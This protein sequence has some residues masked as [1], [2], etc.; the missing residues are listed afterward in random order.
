MLIDF[1]VASPTKKT[2]K[3]IAES[4]T[5]L[6]YRTSFEPNE[7]NSDWTTICAT[8]MMLSHPAVLAIQQELDTLAKPFD[9]HAD[10]WGTFGN[11]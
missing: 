11:A 10:G 7:D 3:Q 4:A 1:Q 6:G 9:G 5:K 8:R 2:A